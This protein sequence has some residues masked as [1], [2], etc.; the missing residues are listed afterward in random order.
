MPD[1][2]RVE[3][4]LQHL[5]HTVQDQ[6]MSHIRHA[7]SQSVI[8]NNSANIIFLEDQIM[9]MEAKLQA[10]KREMEEYKRHVQMCQK[11][12][13]MKENCAWGLGIR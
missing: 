12:V 11:V 4:S 10:K 6:E 5:Q 8:E 3:A 13:C 1:Q 7:D 9:K 2:D